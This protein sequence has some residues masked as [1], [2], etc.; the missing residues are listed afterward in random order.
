MLTIDYIWLLLVILLYATKLI[1]LWVSDDLNH[2]LCAKSQKQ[3][4]VSDIYCIA[5]TE[6]TKNH[7]A[8]QMDFAQSFYYDKDESDPTLSNLRADQR[9]V[10]RREAKAIEP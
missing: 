4:S 6:Q 5:E 3:T 9:D 2:E 1:W 7:R 8:D 10:V